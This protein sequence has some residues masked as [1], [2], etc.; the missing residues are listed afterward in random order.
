MIIQLL[1]DWQLK[2]FTE[3]A[4]NKEITRTDPRA[5]SSRTGQNEQ[6]R[7]TSQVMLNSHKNN[8][9]RMTKQLG[10]LFYKHWTCQSRKHALRCMEQMQTKCPLYY[11][12]KPM[13]VWVSKSYSATKIY[14]YRKG[15]LHIVK[16]NR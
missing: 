16:T 6:L 8:Y 9:G 12:K 7:R 2:L 4:E 14:F 3:R 11:I 1:S 10:L 5:S 13:R 15:G